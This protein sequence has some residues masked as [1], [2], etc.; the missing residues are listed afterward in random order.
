MTFNA[1]RNL[2]LQNLLLIIAIFVAFGCANIQRPL[3][4]PRDK[5]P[6]KLLKATPANS[7]RN[8]NAKIIQLDFDEYFKLNSI[9]Q[10]ITISPDVAKA[11][12]YSVRQ[13]SLI[14][15]LKDTLEKNTT[16][17]INFGKAIADVNEGNVLKNFTYVF[18]TGSHIDSLTVS[19]VVVN[20]LS[21]TK[22]KDVTVM[23]I[24]LKLDS[25]YYRKKKPAIYATTDTAG[26]FKMSNL[27]TGDYK[28]YALKETN[29]NKIY[30]ADDELIG[31]TKNIIHL[32][33]DTANIRLQIFKQMPDKLRPLERRIDADGKLFFTFNKG[34]PNPGVKIQ[35]PDL[36]AQKIVE[37][38][39]N[40]DTATIYLK[41]MKFD[42]I[43]VSFLNNGKPLDTITL[44]RSQR[45]TYKRKI[46][47]E[48]N[49]PNDK[50]KPGA[51]LMVKANYPIASIDKGRITLT[52]DSVEVNETDFNLIPNETD[53]KKF[54]IKYKWR[55]NKTYSLAFNEGTFADI[56]GDKNSRL[57][58]KFELDKPENYSKLILNV[59]VPDTGHYVVQLLNT[60]DVEIRSDVITKS[61]KLV[62][63]NYYTTKYHIKVIYDTNH[64]GKWDTGSVKLKTQPENIWLSKKEVSLRAN[65]DIT[66]DVVIPKETKS[67]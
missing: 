46:S 38:G 30:D 66:E 7:T 42:S 19:G 67:P 24:P 41:T 57:P 56:Y 34:I 23:L 21:Q 15:K 50:L 65:W 14:I 28:I 36:D 52:E 29:N 61:E 60:S 9:Y 55:P 27:H 1:K 37:F 53:S 6:P 51:D 39:R 31:F 8:F 25:V 26:N 35:D 58:K 40:A 10:E 59:T 54:I 64:N 16:Y 47:L 22:E 18:S 20:P 33:R 17:V 48:Y 49:T 5:T 63:N 2:I 12:E 62:Y 32:N 44:R 13:K 11:P 4:G 43:K 3:G 45:D